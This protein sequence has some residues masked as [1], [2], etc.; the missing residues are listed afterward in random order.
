MM[1]AERMRLSDQHKAD[2]AT[3]RHFHFP[4][5]EV[6]VRLALRQWRHAMDALKIC[7]DM[8][9][10]AETVLAEVLNNIVEHG[11]RDGTLGWIDLH[12]DVIAS[13]LRLVVTDQG[14]PMPPHLLAPPQH[15]ARHPDDYPLADL[16]EGGFGW[17]IIRCLACDLHH[18]SHAGGNRLSFVIPFCDTWG[19]GNPPAIRQPE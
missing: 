5:G 12:C 6:S 2:R 4:A 11:Q 10:R 8:T 15:A 3:G 14:R 7:P 9:D 18:Q 19:R 13:G 16:P 1:I 17:S